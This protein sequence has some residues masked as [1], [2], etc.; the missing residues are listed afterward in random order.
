MP[1]QEQLALLETSDPSSFEWYCLEKREEAKRHF[2]AG[3]LSVYV[4]DLEQA[5]QRAEKIFRLTFEDHLKR[6]NI[7]FNFGEHGYGKHLLSP[8]WAPRVVPTAYT[9][10][11]NAIFLPP[12]IFTFVDILKGYPCPQFLGEDGLNLSSVWISE[13]IGLNKLEIRFRKTPCVL[14]VSPSV[15]EGERVWT[16]ELWPIGSGEALEE[17]V[18][19]PTDWASSQLRDR[20]KKAL[21]V[22]QLALEN[23]L[24]RQVRLQENYLRALAFFYNLYS[25]FN[26]YSE[27]GIIVNPLG[28]SSG[29]LVSLPEMRVLYDAIKEMSHPLKIDK[30]SVIQRGDFILIFELAGQPYSFYRDTFKEVSLEQKA[31]RV[32]LNI[33]KSELGEETCEKA[34]VKRG[35]GR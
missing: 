1:K 19:T 22:R 16:P 9:L 8:V 11:T 21:V 5:E 34:T 33:T 35:M 26:I 32:A 2:E 20:A 7:G 15:L 12:G 6:H 17:I 28:S 23:N 13:E 27:L 14:S 10:D 18:K 31:Q 25:V 30:W 4:D 29:E 24:P 3:S